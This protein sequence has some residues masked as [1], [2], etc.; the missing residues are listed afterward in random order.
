M[1]GVGSGAARDPR[2]PSPAKG[3]V[4]GGRFPRRLHPWFP[5]ELQSGD[6]FTAGRGR[7]SVS[8]A[9]PTGFPRARPGRRDPGEGGRI[10]GFPTDPEENGG[11]KRPS[12]ASRASDPMLTPRGIRAREEGRPS[13][14][15]RPF[16]RGRDTRAFRI[17]RER[18][19]GVGSGAAAIPGFPPPRKGGFGAGGFRGGFTPGSP[20]SSS[21]GTA[22]RPD[23]AAPRFPWRNRQAFPAPDQDG[24]IQGKAAGFAGFPRTPRKTAD[25]NAPLTRR[26]RP[27]LCLPLAES[28]LARKGVPVSREGRSSADAIPGRFGFPRERVNGVGSG[29]AAIPRFLLLAKGRVRGGRFPGAASP[30][31]PPRA[32]VRGRLHGR[33]RPPLGFPGGT[34]RLSPRPTRTARSRGRRPDS[35]V[36][37]GP[38][39]KRRTETP[40]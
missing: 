40:L 23:A 31:V 15:R 25:G 32:P 10:L 24:A 19:K 17:P 29:A 30:L 37:H 13:P 12:N 9:E 8:L 1:N 21:P 22:S 2:L 26:E 6:G 39:G 28:E 4:R 27:T 36:S 5:R 34:D 35:R 20:A 33:T 16:E 38:R 11:R 14:R 7:P 18:V 3:R